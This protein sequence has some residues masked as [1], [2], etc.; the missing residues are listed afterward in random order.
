MGLFGVNEAVMSELAASSEMPAG[1]C[2]FDVAALAESG[3]VISDGFLLDGVQH[4]FDAVRA[5]GRGAPRT[6]PCWP[7]APAAAAAD[8]RRQRPSG[9]G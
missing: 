7:T 1:A 3:E 4:V 9:G 8:P 6:P 2:L 5:G